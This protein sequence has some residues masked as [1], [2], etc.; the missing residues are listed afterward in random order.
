M[1]KAEKK[2]FFDQKRKLLFPEL[3]ILFC[4]FLTFVMFAIPF[5]LFFVNLS[6]GELNYDLSAYISVEDTSFG[7]FEYELEFFDMTLFLIVCCCF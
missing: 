7:N 4:V 5:Y 6:L 3:G 2:S 1:T